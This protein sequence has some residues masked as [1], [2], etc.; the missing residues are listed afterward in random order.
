VV[1]HEQTSMKTPLPFTFY[2]LGSPL[3]KNTMTGELLRFKRGA[4]RQFL[5]YMLHCEGNADNKTVCQ[6]LDMTEEMLG[7]VIT[8]CNRLFGAGI[9]KREEKGIWLKRSVLETDVVKFRELTQM[10]DESDNIAD[11]TALLRKAFALVRG[12]FLAGY[13]DS[14]WAVRQQMIWQVE[15]LA[16]GKTLT[17]LYEH[18]NLPR[19]AYEIMRRLATLLPA[20]EDVA[21]LLLD[22]ANTLGTLQSPRKGSLAQ[23]TAFTRQLGERSLT[24]TLIEAKEWNLFFAA[25]W[26]RLAQAER[27]ALERLSVLRGSFDAETAA[28]V[29]GITPAELSRLA[30]RA[31][32]T[33]TANRFEMPVLVRD[34]VYQQMDAQ[35]RIDFEWAYH[36]FVTLT[37]CQCLPDTANPASCHYW[38][39]NLS[40]AEAIFDWTLKRDKTERQQFKLYSLCFLDWAAILLFPHQA[41]ALYGILQRWEQEK[42]KHF[43]LGGMLVLRLRHLAF[44]FNKFEESLAYYQAAE[45]WYAHHDQW[46]PQSSSIETQ[47]LALHHSGKSEQAA[48]L[49][50]HYLASEPHLPPNQ[51]CC[52][53][54]LYSDILL[55]LK[56]FEEALQAGRQAEE[57]GRHSEPP[58]LAS[59]LYHQGL[60]LHGLGSDDEAIVAF[61][62]SLELFAQMEDGHGQAD[63]LQQLGNV[64]ARQ[65]RFG[66]AMRQV[67]EALQI[68]ESIPQ[69]QSR[70]ACLRSLGDVLKLKGNLEGARVAYCEG[71]AFWENEVAE[72]R[73]GES[74][75]RRF[76][77]RLNQ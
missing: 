62:A 1:G 17:D 19:E 41:Q 33:Q 76:Q 60:A 20:N 67:T 54:N 77:E 63:C 9:T 35:Q 49:I 30:A 5:A 66:Q 38:Q 69:L 40:H 59:P 13:A 75:V 15:S 34:W 45:A 68:Y 10:A 12:D 72:G 24:V 28:T 51:L 36:H 57:L 21:A 26:E 44:H 73:G 47:I 71:L 56:R 6:M 39:A 53:V 43:P 48:T 14:S 7:Q 3:V 31:M 65:K 18:Q 22:Y 23:W 2:V 29:C 37:F 11:R 42:D 70:A 64:H 46:F 50:E 8:D 58:F 25:R 61:D 27:A 32:L 16:V 4:S 74:W 52:L 55:A